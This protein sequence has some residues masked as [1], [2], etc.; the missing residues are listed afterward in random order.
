MDT[1]PKIVI[2]INNDPQI[3]KGL[4]LLLEDMSLNVL[5]AT[6]QKNLEQINTA[7]PDLL[8]FPSQFD[9][10]ESG[11]DLIKNLRVQYNNNIP[12]I[13]IFTNHH[14]SQNQENDPGLTLLSDQVR[15]NVLRQKVKELLE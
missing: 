4:T 12:A 5:A 9:N 11:I 15:P 14:F 2:V 7:W 3:L 13:L 1:Q 8:I 6:N 10:G